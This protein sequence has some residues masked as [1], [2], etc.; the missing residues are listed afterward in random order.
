MWVSKQIEKGNENAV[1]VGAP[2]D[3][4]EGDRANLENADTSV[5]AA[6]LGT[7]ER[8]DIT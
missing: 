5:S 6:I 2:G 8:K 1:D 4:Q 7:I 3:L